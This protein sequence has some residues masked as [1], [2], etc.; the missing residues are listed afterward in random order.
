M[1]LTYDRRLRDQRSRVTATGA[2]REAGEEICIS[3]AQRNVHVAFE[4]LAV[5]VAAPFSFWL[6]TRPE[7]PPWAR[8]LSA[9]IGVSTLVV[10]GGLLLSYLSKKDG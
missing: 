6:A 10:D 7:L 4:G 8:G 5:V 2:V 1:A 3:K 9:A